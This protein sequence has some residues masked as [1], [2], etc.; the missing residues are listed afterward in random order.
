MEWINADDELPKRGCNVIVFNCM[1]VTTAGW[2]NLE[3]RFF[4]G[5]AYLNGVTHWMPLPPAPK[6]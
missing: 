5:P 1:C 3:D 2:D 4:I 6:E